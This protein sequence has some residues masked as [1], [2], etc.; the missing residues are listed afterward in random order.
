MPYYLTRKDAGWLPF[1]YPAGMPNESAVGAST[2][3]VA[4]SAGNGGALA[5]PVQLDAPMA[6]ESYSIWNTDT[7][8]AR[9]AEA[10]LYV[11]NNASATMVRI[12]GSSAAFSF[13]PGGAAAR[14]T[15][16]NVQS[17]PVILQPGLYW[18]VLRNTSATQTFGVGAMA[19][20]NFTGPL[21]RWSTAT[22]VAALSG[23]I[24]LTAAPW[25]T[26]NTLYLV[27][28]N[29]RIWGQSSAFA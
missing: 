7:A 28:L 22:G 26:L 23:T 21:Q 3:F 25:A 18:F 29:G 13:T 4:V 11:D 2:S 14:Q 9:T 19:Q 6:L 10:A 16:A 12:A 1:A 17:A 24:D 15:S 5:T 8:N 20:G 27:R